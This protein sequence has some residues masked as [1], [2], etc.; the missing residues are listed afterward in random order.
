[1]TAPDKAGMTFR[2]TVD[3]VERPVKANLPSGDSLVWHILEW[4]N[5]SSDKTH[6]LK[7]EKP[8]DLSHVST[9]N[10]VELDPPEAEECEAAFH[11]TRN[12]RLWEP[13]T[14]EQTQVEKTDTE[15]ANQAQ[16]RDGVKK[17]V[18]L[19][20]LNI[21]YLDTPKITIT[22]ETLLKAIRQCVEY[23]PYDMDSYPPRSSEPYRILV[24]H[25]REL[26]ELCEQDHT[27]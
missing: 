15:A 18:T 10:V 19:K 22:S 11:V 16:A 9:D 8:F 4:S 27:R 6:Q 3:E 17:D 13:K 25:M 24:Y 2:N 7:S 20:D 21:T 23:Y 5:R 12:V 1:M 26:R 14:F